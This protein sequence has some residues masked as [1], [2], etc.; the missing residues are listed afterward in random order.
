MSKPV[1]LEKTRSWRKR[2]QRFERSGLTIADFCAMENVTAANFQYWRR[3]LAND[4]RPSSGT[5]GSKKRRSP[6]SGFLPVRVSLATVDIRLPGGASVSIPSGDTTAL[7]V[8]IEVIVQ[9][10]SDKEK[11]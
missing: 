10:S 5:Q 1:D 11:A 2:F 3:R 4:P 6:P 8:A 9:R 7:R